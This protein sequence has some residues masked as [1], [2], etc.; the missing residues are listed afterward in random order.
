MIAIPLFAQDPIDARPT[1]PKLASDLS[2]PDALR[3]E[4]DAPR[5]PVGV[6]SAHGPCSGLPAW[7]W[8]YRHIGAPTST[9]AVL[10]DGA[11]NGQHELAGGRARNTPMPRRLLSSADHVANTHFAVAL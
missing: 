2:G 3:L 6:R 11:A 5:Q 10:A 4:P 1:N 8:R 9:R 7:P